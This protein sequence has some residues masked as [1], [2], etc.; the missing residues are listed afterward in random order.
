MRGRKGVSDIYYEVLAGVFA[1]SS[2]GPNIRACC[3]VD[4][5]PLWRS[6]CVM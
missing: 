6:Y 3:R 5:S 1:A 2:I 4:P